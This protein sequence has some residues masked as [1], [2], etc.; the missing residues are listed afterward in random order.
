ML[1]A[2]RMIE[3]E[4][5]RDEGW[6]DAEIA[7]QLGVTVA[8]LEPE[9]EPAPRAWAPAPLKRAPRVE[10]KRRM[11][12]PAPVSER[13]AA[14]AAPPAPHWGGDTDPKLVE[15]VEEFRDD[16]AHLE[17]IVNEMPQSA[18]ASC[19]KVAGG[20]TY[21]RAG[22]AR[23]VAREMARS[24]VDAEWWQLP[25]G[26]RE[27]YVRLAGQFVVALEAIAAKKPGAGTARERGDDEL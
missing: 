26:T 3:M 2:E 6:D 22:L 15:V 16:E 18:R 10:R 25:I 11:A 4:F 23:R 14:P 17:V 5:L 19:V 8:E 24:R 12:P 1:T 13:P 7:E 20:V 27:G 21:S 9:P